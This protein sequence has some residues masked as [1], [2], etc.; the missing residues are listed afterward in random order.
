MAMSE[1]DR[2]VILSERLAEKQKDVER[3]ALDLMF[4]SQRG[5]AGA[6]A[7]D[8]VAGA[9]KR[10]FLGNPAHERVHWVVHG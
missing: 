5:N 4:A 1:V 7:S 10:A 3:Q 8:S 6:G 9:A 2:E